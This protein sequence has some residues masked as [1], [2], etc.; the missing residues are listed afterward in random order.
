[1]IFVKN[2]DPRMNKNISDFNTKDELYPTLVRAIA[3]KK[4]QEYSRIWSGRYWS[5]DHKLNAIFGEYINTMMEDI[6]V[7]FYEVLH[8]LSTVPS[9]T[10]T[11]L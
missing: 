10:G 11:T 9:F 4:I 1:M 5:L 2:T 6:R 8:Y 3:Q 7:S